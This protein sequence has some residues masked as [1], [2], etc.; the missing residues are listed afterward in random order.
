MTAVPGVPTA[1]RLGS[2]PFP[3]LAVVTG[4]CPIDTSAASD[5][6]PA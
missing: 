5:T 3:V 1:A 6:L 4:A 2:A